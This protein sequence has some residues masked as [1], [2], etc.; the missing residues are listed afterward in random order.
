MCVLPI[1]A[2]DGRAEDVQC[3]INKGKAALASID[4]QQKISDSYCL[5]KD[6]LQYN[7]LL[8][9]ANEKSCKYAECHV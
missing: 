5:N 7:L 3:W 6:L 1:T 8:S 4:F 9:D 2:E